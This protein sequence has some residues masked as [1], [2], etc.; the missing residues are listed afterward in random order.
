[1]KCSLIVPAYNA[2]R[3]IATCLESALRQSLDR[4][5]Y[6]IIVVDDGSTDKTPEIVR[7]YPV[8]LVRQQN[9]GPASARNRGAGEARGKVLVFTD[10]DC[11]LDFDF[12]KNI[13]STFE[14]D[15][16][17]CGVQGSYRTKQKQF[18][19]QFVQA[20]VETRY[21]KMARDEYIDF[22]GTYAAAYR[23][24]VF[25]RYG[26][27]DTGFPSASGED[28]EFSYR[29]HKNGHKMRFRPDTFVY[30]QHPTELK[31]YLKTKFYRGYWR[32][33]LYRRNVKKVIKDSYT[34]QSLKFQ[35]LSIPFVFFFGPLSAFD[36][37]WSIPLIPAV[38]LFGGN[39]VPFLRLFHE[40]KYSKP[41]LI[42]FILFLRAAALFFGILFGIANELSH[43]KK[44]SR[45]K[46][47]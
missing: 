31:H 23:K 1:M 26:G 27:F 17:I 9:G 21:K 34:P 35:V 44:R 36:M 39:S 20:E 24:D 41:V 7:G 33:R 18:M 43:I 45:L 13:I 22:I 4:G 28:T 42:P 5:E 38:A 46:V 10:S 19:A 2:E 25:Q 32:V 12:L 11:E 30:H 8:M 29:L 15:P 16:E 14:S 37:L 40:R 47:A 6:E 3:T